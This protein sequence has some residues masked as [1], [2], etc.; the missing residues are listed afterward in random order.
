MPGIILRS[1]LLAVLRSS[2]SCPMSFAASLAA[3]SASL[4]AGA[5]VVGR[6]GPGRGG[7]EQT[8]GEQHRDDETDQSLH[9]RSP[10]EGTSLT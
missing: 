6:L 2:G 3:G 9:G 7:R 1:A 8:G 10:F 4:L 5:G